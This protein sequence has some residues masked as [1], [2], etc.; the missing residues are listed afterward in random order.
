MQQKFS[1][2]PTLEVFYHLGQSCKHWKV[3]S[4]NRKCMDYFPLDSPDSLID[5]LACSISVH[6]SRR[7]KKPRCSAASIVERIWAADSVSIFPSEVCFVLITETI[8]QDGIYFVKDKMQ[9]N[10]KIWKVIEIIEL[11]T[12][13]QSTFNSHEFCELV[14]TLPGDADNTGC[15]RYAPSLFTGLQELL[16]LLVIW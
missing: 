9:D 8:L 2:R 5:F 14:P 7:V 12:S 11:E 10:C 3:E 1:Q 15:L 4:Q 13:L 6:C 16:S